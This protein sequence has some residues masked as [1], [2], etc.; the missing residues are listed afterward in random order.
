MIH[1]HSA[2]I[3]NNVCLHGLFYFLSFSFVCLGGWGRARV[4][5]K[6]RGETPADRWT[7]VGSRKKDEAKRT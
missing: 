2:C 1:V 6:K 5:A 4:T 3:M 7:D